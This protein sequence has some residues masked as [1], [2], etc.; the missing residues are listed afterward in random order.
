MSALP[1]EN[2]EKLPHF[3]STEPFDLESIEKLTPEQERIYFASQ[4]TLMWWKFRQH[5]VAVWSGVF[6]AILY[7]SIF[8]SEFLSPY[9]MTKRHVKDIYAPPQGIHLFH[10]GSF[11]GPFVYPYKVTRNMETL[12]RVFTVNDKKPQPLRFFCRG[13]KYK[14]FGFVKSNLHLVCPPKKGQL[15]PVGDR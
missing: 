8:I 13:D 2:T 10:K 11:V 5:R 1:P 15:L 4:L 9:D 14:W 7:A 6:L 12:Q 3:V